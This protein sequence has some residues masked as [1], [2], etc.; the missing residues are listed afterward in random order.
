MRYPSIQDPIGI[1]TPDQL[2]MEVRLQHLIRWSQ[3]PIAP[4]LPAL[5]L[6]QTKYLLL[7]LASK[8]C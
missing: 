6:A 2:V 5:P 8:H 7:M 3:Y 1:T 4:G